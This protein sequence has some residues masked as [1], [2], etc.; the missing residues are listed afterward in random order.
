[1]KIQ[2]GWIATTGLASSVCLGLIGGGVSWATPDQATTLADAMT[3]AFKPAEISTM[4]AKAGASTQSGGPEI[5]ELPER[6]RH[7]L[8]VSNDVG[9]ALLRIF[10]Q[11]DI[12]TDGLIQELAQSAALYHAVTDDLAGMTVDD[13]DGQRVVVQAGAAMR[14]GRFSE[15][16]AQI[17]QLEDREAAIAGRPAEGG[18]ASGSAIIQ[19]QL[20]A[21]EARTLLGKIA[22][23]EL[24]YG[25]AAGDFQLARQRLAP[26]GQSEATELRSAVVTPADT[27]DPPSQKAI[28]QPADGQPKAEASSLQRV[29]TVAVKADTVMVSPTVVHDQTAV[30]TGPVQP[31]A[32]KAVVPQ[33]TQRPPAAEP[34]LSADVLE[35]LLKRG[36]ALLALG[37]LTGARL[38]YERAALAGEARGATGVAQTYDPRVLLQIGARG[39]QGDAETAADWYRKALT[40]GDSSAAARLR[41]LSQNSSQ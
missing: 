10:D 38:L 34:A 6:L 16:E 11:Q 14:T 3:R 27:A 23:M 1:M 25:K 40:L 33:A 15:A 41:L 28:A 12:G 7:A 37:D 19:H 13:P 36:D 30:V 22:L 35:L 2:N 9:L 31:A 18:S 5:P 21:A 17:Q 4:I 24:Q 32:I 29:A 26:S 20:A 8:D 39:I